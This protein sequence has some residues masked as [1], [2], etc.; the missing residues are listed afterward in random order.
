MCG[1]RFFAIDVLA[2]PQSHHRGRGV[3]VV[4]RGDR[5]RLDVGLFEHL[6]KIDIRLGLRKIAAGLAQQQVVD[7]AQRHDV[8]VLQVVDAE[9]RLVGGADKRDVQLLVG[10][11]LFGQYSAANEAVTG[12]QRTDHGGLCEETSRRDGDEFIVSL[13]G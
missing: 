3:D 5:H 6:A 1:E 4:G 12:R 8:L 10:R 7:V 2:Q 13:S 9:P 11:S